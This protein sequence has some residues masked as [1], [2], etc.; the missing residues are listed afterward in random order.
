MLIDREI[1]K[2]KLRELT[3]LNPASISKLTRGQNVNTDVLLS[4]CDALDCRI[5]EI[6]EVVSEQECVRING[7]VTLYTGENGILESSFAY[8]RGT[9]NEKY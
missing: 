2:Q 7:L 8:C 6:V 1:S 4:I 9:T 5:E 3:G